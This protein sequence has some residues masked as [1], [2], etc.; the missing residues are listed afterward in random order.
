[1]KS[2]WTKELTALTKAKPSVI[3]YI[4][5]L[6]SRL[7]ECRDT[8]LKHTK[9]AC[10]NSK[11][12]YNTKAISRSFVPGDKVLVLL[13]LPGQIIDNSLSDDADIN[14]SEVTVCVFMIS[15]CLLWATSAVDISNNVSP[16]HPYGGTGIVYKR[17]I[18]HSITVVDTGKPR[19]TAVIIQSNKGPALPVNVYMPTDYGTHD[20]LQDYLDI[21]AKVAALL[22]ESHAVLIT[23]GDFSTECNATCRFY[24]IF[25]QFL[26]DSHLVH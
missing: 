26:I 17:K 22:N 5:D 3:D 19:M 6:I 18:S 10:E 1:M 11:R 4:L 23:T 8:A 21:C 14:C 24:E 2:L 7:E 20:S 9:Q 25:V 12:W 16:G 15:A 13:P